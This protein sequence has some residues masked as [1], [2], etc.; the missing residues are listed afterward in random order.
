MMEKKLFIKHEKEANPSYNKAKIPASWQLNEAQQAFIEDLWQD[1]A[2]EIERC[3]L[4]ETD[5]N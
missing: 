1:D 2:P 5:V 4:P 3:V